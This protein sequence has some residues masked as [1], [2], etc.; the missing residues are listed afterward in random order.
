MRS[1]TF[2]DCVGGFTA[3]AL[4][5]LAACRPALAAEEAEVAW[6]RDGKVEL[7]A[8]ARSGG[9]TATST[10][11]ASDVVV[12]LGSLWKL[13]VFAYLADARASEPPYACTANRN[14]VDEE[15]RYCCQPGESV[16]RAQA[17]SRSCAPYFAPARLG[18]DAGAWRAYWQRQPA[19]QALQDLAQLAPD[20]NVRLRDLLTVLSGFSPTARGD[21]RS[22]LLETGV[23][24]YGREAW[25]Q[26]GT[27]MRYK[28][29]SWHRVDGSAFGGAAGWL[30]DGTP[31]WF[32][33]RGSSRR[34]LA[35]WGS[36]LATALPAF[37][38]IRWRNQEAGDLAGPCVDV[39]FFARYPLRAVFA[40]NA[41]QPEKIAALPGEMKGR[42]RLEF[43]NGNWLVV[44]S[45]GELVLSADAKEGRT[46][47][48]IGGR[49]GLN[50]YIARVI[51]R[52]GSSASPQSARALAIAARSY[53]TQNARFEAGC[54]R[55]ADAS[56]TQ[57]VSPQPPSRNALAAAWFTDEVVLK[58]VAVRYHA[59]APAANRLVWRDA[60][61][62]AG[63]GW[64]F[65]RILMAAYPAASIASLS[66]QEDCARFTAA[67]TWLAEA[68]PGWSTRLA[69]EP[70]FEPPREALRIC[71]LNNGNPY[72]DQQRLRIYVRGW[73]NVNER[74]TLAHEYLHL[75]F[76]FHPNGADEEYIERLAHRLIEG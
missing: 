69:R 60:V 40:A 35:A 61:A 23:E 73:R 25:Q 53:L 14:A 58:G 30:A 3:L 59:D 15:E 67:E 43:A 49:F 31:F 44:E 21:A 4:L 68:V 74:L 71:A 64:D 27:G 2:A 7:R 56:A 41:A 1:S 55:I 6:L 8:L 75:A 17:L 62:Q 34:A 76:R 37:S 47:L 66:G 29:Y 39:D 20:T 12:P 46:R 18:I 16:A 10:R 26:L 51:D 38:P 65:E 52:E 19:A 48:A 50:E 54:W 33:A 11:D 32:G 36:E 13:F 72:S 24:G 57:R 28:T 22:A 45:H 9:H 5:A 42:Y 70:G 63:Q